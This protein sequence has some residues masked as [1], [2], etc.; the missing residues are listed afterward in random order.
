ML[1]YW[2][3]ERA[4]E[5]VLPLP[6]GW[7]WPFECEQWRQEQL[8]DLSR[9][10]AESLRGRL[11]EL[12][13]EKGHAFANNWLSGVIEHYTLLSKVTVMRP[14]ISKEV[15]RLLELERKGRE[16][17]GTA[18][19]WLRHVVKRLHFCD[20]M[21]TEFDGEQLAS[22]AWKRSNYFEVEMM[23]IYVENGIE[24]V[25]GFMQSQLVGR[26]KP[27]GSGLSLK[28]S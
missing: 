8:K 20:K 5:E 4:E 1:S 21:I 11:D 17:K 13:Q 9:E 6:A 23:G 15:K 25:K 2:S 27:K 19:A 10:D 16:Q 14:V 22:W 3:Y 12:D 7:M 18:I 28:I 26:G 24:A